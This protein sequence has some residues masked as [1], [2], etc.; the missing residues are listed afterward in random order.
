MFGHSVG[1]ETTIETSS[2]DKR[3][4]AALSL[5]SQVTGSVLETGIT[6]PFMMLRSERLTLS[7]DELSAAGVTRE[8]FE[9]MYAALDTPI[10]SGL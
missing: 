7:D 4:K 9:A 3:I 10:L 1:G 5:D 6:Q 8:Q 2:L